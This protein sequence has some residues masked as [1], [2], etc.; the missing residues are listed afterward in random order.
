MLVPV[1]TEEFLKYFSDEISDGLAVL[2]VL[3]ICFSFTLIFALRIPYK[4]LASEYAI[5]IRSACS[6]LL[7]RKV[8]NPDIILPLI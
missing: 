7:Y 5:K 4:Y 3:L 6:G 8:S 2:Y 1:I